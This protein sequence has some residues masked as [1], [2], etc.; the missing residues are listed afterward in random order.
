MALVRYEPLIAYVETESGINI[1]TGLSEGKT[2]GDAIPIRGNI[3]PI[4]GEDIKT[5]PAG[6]NSVEFRSF[7]IDPVDAYV[8]DPQGL[9]LQHII[10]HKGIRYRVWHMEDWDSGSNTIPHYHAILKRESNKQC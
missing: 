5:L 7:W 4:T 2:T 8:I 10:E 3:Q 1:D 9:K 6:T